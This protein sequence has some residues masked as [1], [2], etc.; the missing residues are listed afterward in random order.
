[1]TEYNWQWVKGDGPHE[2]LRDNT[3]TFRKERGGQ[4]DSIGYIEPSADGWYIETWS[5]RIHA[6][7]LPASLSRKEAKAVAK[8]ILLSLKPTIR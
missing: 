6:A 5:P 8:T 3:G 2:W 4:S 7:T 1:M